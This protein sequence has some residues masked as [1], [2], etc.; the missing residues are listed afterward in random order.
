VAMTSLL[1]QSM[2]MPIDLSALTKQSQVTEAEFYAFCL[3]NRD[4]RI[5]R[6][7]QGDIIVQPPAF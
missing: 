6:S 1:I 4:L 5:E 3:A 2:M 7:A